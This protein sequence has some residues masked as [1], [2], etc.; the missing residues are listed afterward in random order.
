MFGKESQTIFQIWNKCKKRR[1]RSYLKFAFFL[2]T[3]IL[4]KFSP[5]KSATT[6]TK[7]ILR[8]NSV[9]GNK[10]DLAT[11]QHKSICLHISPVQKSCQMTDFQLTISNWNSTHDNL[12]TGKISP[13]SR[14]CDKYRVWLDGLLQHVLRPPCS[15]IS[16]CYFC[17]L[18][19]LCHLKWAKEHKIW[20]GRRG[21][22]GGDRAGKL[23]KK[24]NRKK[25]DEKR[26]RKKGNKKRG[27]KTKKRSKKREKKEK[28][29]KRKRKKKKKER[30]TS[31]ERKEREADV[32]ETVLVAAGCFPWE[33]FGDK[34][35]RKKKKKIEEKKKEKWRKSRKRK[36]EK[37]VF[38]RQC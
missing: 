16:S 31:K 23:T 11:K 17:W 1:R 24:K 29:G 2:H 5:H 38:E 8:Q 4:A 9:N 19:V 34:F 33:Q 14:V 7:L 10:T 25:E 6:S 3:K 26:R 12:P 37:R 30:K 18:A 20:K 15:S 13:P 36:K 27:K 32:W 35:E 28:E 22:A 21:G